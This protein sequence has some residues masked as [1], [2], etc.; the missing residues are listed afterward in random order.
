MVVVG[1]VGWGRRLHAVHISSQKC[2]SRA[3]AQGLSAA[4]FRQLLA[5]E[6]QRRANGGSTGRLA[7]VPPFGASK[8]ASERDLTVLS[9]NPTFWSFR[10]SDC[11]FLRVFTIP[12]RGDDS[13]DSFD[14]LSPSTSS[15]TNTMYT[16]ASP[17]RSASQ[18][19]YG[20]A[21]PVRPSTSTHHAYSQALTPSDAS[22]KAVRFQNQPL[23]PQQQQQQVAHQPPANTFSTPA[24]P[25]Y[26]S[27]AAI[28]TSST[29]AQSPRPAASAAKPSAAPPSVPV[30]T[31][32]ASG[33]AS[34][35]ALSRRLKWNLGALG[36]LWIV[37]ALTS[38]PRDAYWYVLDL[39]Y[40]HVGGTTDELVDAIVAWILWAISVV[41]VFNLVEATVLVRRSTSSAST[42]PAANG[43]VAGAAVGRGAVLGFQSPQVA[44]SINFVAAS[45]MRG[46]PKTR[47]SNIGPGSPISHPKRDSPTQSAAGASASM[48]Y[49]QFSPSLRRTSSPGSSPVAA[50]RSA[51][52]ATHEFGVAAA[53]S[54]SPLAAFRARH[55]G[56]AP[57][58]SPSPSSLRSRSVTPA[59]ASWTEP[60]VS[61]EQDDPNDTFLGDESFE[62]DRALRSL[63]G[64]M[65]AVSSTPA[66][67]R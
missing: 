62:V 11:R 12:S 21:T 63:R 42:A 22:S 64:S 49:S 48:D 59:A 51:T 24:R 8:S 57:H 53:A 3:L 67:Y 60:E 34:S 17:G 38:R 56:A 15:D 61:F 19:A 23:P 29:V 40:M 66:P 5:V 32:S 2:W 20:F 52:P 14:S 39:V 18:S 35:I 44:K 9:K 65:G 4:P 54:S 31:P 46:S 27:P 41:L 16:T 10:S 28:S 1:G 36:L 33:G 50:A 7:H 37:P 26:G 45:R 55:S 30:R 13:F 25:T 58:A 6:G 47:T 43:A